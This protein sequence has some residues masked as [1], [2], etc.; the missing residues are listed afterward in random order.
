MEISSAK[1]ISELTVEDP[2]YLS[3]QYD[4]NPFDYSLDGLDHDFQSISAE[5][6]SS[7]PV[8]KTPKS[9]HTFNIGVGEN[10]PQ[11]GMD[12]RPAKLLKTSSWNSFSTDRIAS[13]A[14][15]SSSLSQL[16]SFENSNSPP[17]SYQQFYGLDCTMNPK[18][19]AGSD[20]GNR[21]FP[22]LI[23]EKPTS[24]MQNCSPKQEQF[25]KRAGSTTRTPLH[26]QDHVIAERKRREKLSQRF[27]A[28]SA[29]VPGLK[30]MDKASVLGDA[31][32]YL[33]QLQ[34][35]VKILE[36]Q[37]AKKTMET[38]VF[39]KKTRISA[40]DDTSTSDENSN[41]HSD[42]P[43]PEVEA[44]ISEKNVLIRIYCEKRKG[45]T[46]KILSEIEKL[47]LTITTS[48]ILPFGNST[49]DMTVV[50]QV[51]NITPFFILPVYL[52]IR[53]QLS[54][55]VAVTQSIACHFGE[56]VEMLN[57]IDS[58]KLFCIN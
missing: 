21:S 17:A 43:L 35:R 14:P 24:M 8:L 49:V 4:L 32:K 1:W 18:N 50:A 9:I 15:A 28:L 38:V 6:Y 34:E 16:I 47:H 30:K 2:N 25:P 5:S 22:N 23:S 44:R 12:P 54:K 37:T 19:E 55:G 31:I 33:K 26:A 27:I 10:I 58:T 51:I 46:A 29:I 11:T 7:Y 13:K 45:C 20:H 36:E 40:D 39:V 42:E 52:S 56:Y 41:S 48:S 57:S 53:N 3:H